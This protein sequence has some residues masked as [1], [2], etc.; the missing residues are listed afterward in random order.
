MVD[1]PCLSATEVGNALSEISK[2]Y[3]VAQKIKAVLLSVLYVEPK[4][5]YSYNT[6]FC[7]KLI[8]IAA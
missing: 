7:R 8:F 5:L 3:R 1:S 6:R 2:I 4:M